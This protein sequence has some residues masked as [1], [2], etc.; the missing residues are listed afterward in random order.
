MRR[1]EVALSLLLAAASAFAADGFVV[2]GGTVVD[3]AGV[4]PDAIVVVAK[5]R[6]QAMGP[7][8]DVRLPKGL[9]IQDGRG[10]YVVAGAPWS[11]AS[12]SRLRASVSA[13]A[14]LRDALLAALRDRSARLRAGGPAEF[15][16]LDKDP[17]ADPANLRAVARAFRDGRELSTAE[18]TAAER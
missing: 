3:A 15:V 18:R 17:L 5:D 11:E 2:V 13:G 9:P 10:S 14:P 4:V 16:V 8:P 1:P 12:V 7:R 6:V